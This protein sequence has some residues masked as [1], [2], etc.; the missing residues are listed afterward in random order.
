[1]SHRRHYFS[2]NFLPGSLNKVTYFF[3][4]LFH[5]N[6][7]IRRVFF[8]KYRCFLTDFSK[9]L[10]DN[11]KCYILWHFIITIAILLDL[12]ISLLISVFPFNFCFPF[13]FLFSLSISTSPFNF[14]FPFQFLLQFLF[15]I[16][17]NVLCKKL[18]L[19]GKI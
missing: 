5:F 1:M 6:Y 15:F 7:Y 19:K 8:I 9:I 17:V 12:W 14:N 11:Q 2:R 16:C 3:L 10:S 4:F 13:Q 18:K